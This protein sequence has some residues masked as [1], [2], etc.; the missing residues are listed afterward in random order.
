MKTGLRLQRVIT[1]VVSGIIICLL[2]N[3]AARAAS[4]QGRLG[5][6]TSIIGKLTYDP[7]SPSDLVEKYR[8]SI[9]NTGDAP[10][11]FGLIFRSQAKDLQ[12]GDQLNYRL[13]GTDQSSLLTTAPDIR[14]AFAH[15]DRP[16]APSETV[17]LEYELVIPRGQFAAPGH[18]RDRVVLELHAM[19]DGG[20]LAGPLLDRASLSFNY[21]VEQIM[22]VNIKG[23]DTTTT[24]SFG[25]LAKGQQRS[26]DIQVRSNASY[27]LRVTSG[28][29][30][31]LAL[32]PKVPGQIWSVPYRATLDGQ[33]LRLARAAPMQI[34]PPTRPEQDASH[35][36]EVMIGDTS[37]KRA[38]R[39]KDVITIE[40]QAARL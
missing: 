39:Y 4:C 30:G 22:S 26:V 1:I 6:E 5:A 36:L 8:I 29:H 7:F 27:R 20:R 23:G 14:A 19:D 13:A 24:L 31:V 40:V 17:Q 18:L 2:M 38:G 35:T 34:L 28:N 11:L 21:G 15:T 10:C 33:P 32:T 3:S 16:V 9:R 25:K 12:L 37:R